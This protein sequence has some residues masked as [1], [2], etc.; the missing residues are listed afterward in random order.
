M[1]AAP[2][3]LRVL[4]PSAR[5]AGIAM[6]SIVAVDLV[7]G[8]G[9]LLL[10]PYHRRTAIVPEHGRAIYLAHALVGVLL[11]IAAVALMPRARRLDRPAWLGAVTGLAGIAV[12]AAGGMLAVAQAT[13]LIGMA[14]ML[15][16]S[17]AAEA[18]YLMPLVDSVP[19]PPE[20]PGGAGGPVPSDEAG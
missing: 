8:M 10:V 9:T 7:L 18:G 20:G 4:P 11:G 13:R 3:P 12:A 1:P 2:P 5:R 6:G 19:P 16:G 17:M 14:L 15:L